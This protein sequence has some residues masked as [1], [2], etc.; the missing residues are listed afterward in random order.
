M[1]PR[2]NLQTTA[3]DHTACVSAIPSVLTHSLFSFDMEA[4]LC[5]QLLLF[6]TFSRLEM[7]DRVSSMLK[8][9]HTGTLGG[10]G[11]PSSCRAVGC[12]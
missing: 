8:G 9:G 4:I 1:S 2:D 11:C 3:Q 5:T 7:V 6:S 10:A 12:G